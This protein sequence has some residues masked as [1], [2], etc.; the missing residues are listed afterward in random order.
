MDQKYYQL[1]KEKNLISK[2]NL[3]IAVS[4]LS[5]V[6]MWLGGRMLE[7][8]LVDASAAASPYLKMFGTVLGGHYMAKAA[9]LATSK[10]EEDEQYYK[11]K[12]AVSN[13]YIEQ[14]LPQAQGLVS[15]VKAGKD[16]LYKIKAENF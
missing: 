14:I 7:G 10:I 16:D 12:I 9:L 11:E 3:D 1:K 5:D 13:F 4:A 8:E 6:T 15:A 2:N